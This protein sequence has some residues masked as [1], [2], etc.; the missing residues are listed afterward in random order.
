MDGKDAMSI[1]WA[2]SDNI[3]G[4]WKR[5]GVLMKPIANASFVD[6]CIGGGAPPLRWGEGKYLLLYHIGN[7]RADGSREYDLGIAVCAGDGR[8]QILKRDEPLLRPETIAETIGDPELGVNNVVFVGG[9][10]FYAG[11]LYFV[12]GGADSVVLG[13]RIPRD[14]VEHYLDSL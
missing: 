12:Y 13:G 4:E 5:R 14:V 2:V 10:Y 1:H 6:T 7:K 11:D 9:A 3:F 8:L